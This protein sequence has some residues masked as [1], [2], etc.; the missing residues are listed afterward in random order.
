MLDVPLRALDC[1]QSV[2][3]AEYFNQR[4]ANHMR[5]GPAYPRIS[6][7]S[8]SV[9]KNASGAH[10]KAQTKVSFHV[11]CIELSASPFVGGQS[12]TCARSRGGSPRRADL[13]PDLVQIESAKKI[14]PDEYIVWGRVLDIDNHRALQ[15]RI[16]STSRYRH[17][18][19]NQRDL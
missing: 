7:P 10:D 8:S 15:G 6:G 11:Q 2:L 19:A 13:K 16:G 12:G 3:P 14:A 4:N 9:S 18:A 5:S 1:R 17:A